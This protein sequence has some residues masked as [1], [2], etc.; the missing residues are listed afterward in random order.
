MEIA[1]T[2]NGNHTRGEFHHID[3][4]QQNEDIPAAEE[5]PASPNDSGQS[6]T[7]NIER[8][9]QIEV[10]KRAL[11]IEVGLLTFL[12]I[13]LVGSLIS[14]R[15]SECKGHYLKVWVGVLVPINFALIIPNL[16]L[17]FN[18]KSFFRQAETRRLEP[19]GTFYTISR[20]L[21]LFWIIWAIVGIA[22]T[23]Q[24][25]E[26][27]DV[28]PKVY[29]MCMAI[30]IFS[31][32]MVGIPIV[33]LCFS[34]PGYAVMYFCF[35]QRIGIEKIRKGS[36]K[37]I[38]KSTKLVKFTQNSTIPQEDATCAICLVEY[39]END[40]LRILNCG[41]HFHAECVTEWLMTNVKCPFCQRD[42]DLSL[43]S[44]EVPLNID[45]PS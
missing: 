35:P 17:Q 10:W 24:A 32:I 44:E 7:R 15:N 14:D 13:L 39:I 40:D 12:N 3:I 4:P 26:C 29:T 36:P 33:L 6:L 19:T 21:N 43:K 25:G 27:A 22:W 2:Q 31:V 23:F 30:S 16:V 5:F 45:I 11:R 18:L 9:K 1:V 38:K 42:I 34:I 8:E 37:L 20:L 28:I 41:H